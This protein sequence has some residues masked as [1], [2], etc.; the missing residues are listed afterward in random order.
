MFNTISSICR[1]AAAGADLLVELGVRGEIGGGQKR[2][3]VGARRGDLGGGGS[4][5]CVSGFHVELMAC[6]SR[7]LAANTSGCVTTV[8]M[9]ISS[10]P[11]ITYRDLAGTFQ[12]IARLSSEPRIG[13]AAKLFVHPY[14]ANVHQRPED[15]DSMTLGVHLGSTP[16]TM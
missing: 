3:R 7:A 8:D 6:S 10:S 5:R 14:G 13:E 15:V 1:M 4:R 16:F 9:S 12:D 2:H 11:A